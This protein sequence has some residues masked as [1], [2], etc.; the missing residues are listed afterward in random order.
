MKINEILKE[1]DDVEHGR[2]MRDAFSDMAAQELVSIEENPQEYFGSH[3]EEVSPEQAQQISQTLASVDDRTF[4]LISQSR[5]VVGALEANSMG[6]GQSYIDLNSMMEVL[7]K[8]QAR[9]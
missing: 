1:N 3:G 4:D 6:D 5:I 8:V 2:H 9:G 7:Q